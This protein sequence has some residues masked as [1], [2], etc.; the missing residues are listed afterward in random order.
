[1]KFTKIPRLSVLAASRPSGVHPSGGNGPQTRFI[2]ERVCRSC[3][4]QRQGAAAVEFALVA[5][6]FF[7]LVLGMIEYGRFVMVQQILTHASREGARVGVLSTSTSSGVTAAA[8]NYLNDLNAAGIHDST[9]TPVWKRRAEN[10]LNDDSATV[11][12]TVPFDKV[13]WLPSPMIRTRNTPLTA[14]TQ[15]RLERA[16]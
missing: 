4:K 5:I 6:P 1:M 7:I 16:P 2:L 15:M 3:R 8:T 9:V 12:V 13:S 11:T 14:V 10:P